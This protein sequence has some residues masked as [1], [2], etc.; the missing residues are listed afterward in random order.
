MHPVTYKGLFKWTQKMYEK[1]GWMFL[2]LKYNES[3]KVTA[4]IQGIEQLRQS[5][6]NKIMTVHEDDRR[7]D[8]EI[9]RG[10][11]VYLQELTKTHL[12][13]S[14]FGRRQVRR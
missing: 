10:Q 2:A 7:D 11:V 1:L 12:R 4:Y 5:I 8:L 9:L 13:V 14:G 3:V 6:E